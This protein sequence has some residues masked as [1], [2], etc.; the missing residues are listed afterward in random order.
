[1]VALGTLVGG[2]VRADDGA[3]TDKLGKKIDNLAFTPASGKPF[4]LYDLKDNQAT[5][6]VFLSLECPV[7]NSYAAPLSELAKAYQDKHVG[8]VGVCVNEDLSADQFARQVEAFHYAFPVARAAPHAAVDAFKAAVTPEAFV[9]DRHFIL[10]Y[11]GRIDDGYAARLKRN[12]QVTRHDLQQALDDV[13]A[14]KP[15]AVPATAAV[16]CAI[17]PALESKRVTTNLTFYK[18]VLPILQTNCQTCHRPGAVGPFA[19]LTHNQAVNW[20]TD[21]KDYT[22]SRKMPPWKPV[23]G[24][25]FHQERKLSDRDIATL[26]AWVDGGTPAGDPKEGPPLRPF[27]DSWQFGKPDLVL[28]APDDYHLSASGNDVFRCFV[29]PTNLTEDKYVVA[30]ELRPGNPRV[31]HHSLLFIDTTGQARK[32]ETEEKE[33]TRDR[34]AKDHGPGYSASMG[35]GFLPRGGLGG[36]APGQM[37]RRLPEGA[38]YFLPKGADVV[39]QLHYHRDGRPETDRTQLGLYF[40]N[41]PVARRFQTM[42]IPGRFVFIPKGNDHYKV[43]GRIWC[44]S[45]CT[46]HSVMPH[47]HMLGREVKVTMTPPGGA[48]QTLIAIKDWDYNWQETYFFKEPITVKAGTRFDIEAIYD[49]SDK[50]PS[51]PFHPPQI[52]FFGQETTNEMCYGFLGATSDQPGR[53]RVDRRGPDAK[54]DLSGKPKGS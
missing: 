4:S 48:P 39:M 11:R 15:V 29:L 9:L 42:V 36:W 28:T 52:V 41:Q 24:A 3:R 45:D 43:E 18:D 8:F 44:R 19:L 5:V 27:S 31:V 32:L 16:G 25:A 7:S 47:M 35:V 34:P 23:D 51:N 49:N 21:I 50:N 14:G 54:A 12:Q 2:G 46:L 1:M 10:R 30:V 38:A 13:L 20:A 6:V 26:A 37:P 33:R 22:Q 40:A 53:I 17:V